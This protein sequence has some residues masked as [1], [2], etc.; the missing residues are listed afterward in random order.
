M[1]CPNEEM[2]FE[3]AKPSIPQW[4]DIVSQRHNNNNT[5]AKKHEAKVIDMTQSSN[6]GSR[7][8]EP[9]TE[10]GSKRKKVITPIK[11]GA[12]DCHFQPAMH[13]QS[14]G[15]HW[16]EPAEISR[17]SRIIWTSRQVASISC[18]GTSP[19][20]KNNNKKLQQH[21]RLE[22]SEGEKGSDG[23]R[24]VAV[25]KAVKTTHGMSRANRELQHISESLPLCSRSGVFVCSDN[26]RKAMSELKVSLEKTRGCLLEA[27]KERGGN[28]TKECI[29]LRETHLSWLALIDNQKV[30]EERDFLG[31]GARIGKVKEC[32]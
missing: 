16:R 23:A 31:M 2:E 9:G 6:T 25:E 10:E 3:M 27:K 14:L 28:V 13:R 5:N 18:E 11:T 20:T 19:E 30:V 21:T 12:S 7:G 26:N 4:M 17:N 32:N 1:Q 24:G 15:L 22:M 29:D 8:T